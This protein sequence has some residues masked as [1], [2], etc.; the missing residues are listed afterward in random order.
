MLVRQDEFS[1]PPHCQSQT[2][3]AV[4]RLLCVCYSWERLG[5]KSTWNF[6]VKMHLLKSVPEF[7]GFLWGASSVCFLRAELAFSWL[8]LCVCCVSLGEKRMMDEWQ[9]IKACPWS[10]FK[11]QM[12]P[13]QQAFGRRLI[14]WKLSPSFNPLVIFTALSTAPARFPYFLSLWFC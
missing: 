8:L 3:K 10:G 1:S 14:E 7:M 9:R 4:C 12:M 11:F 6:L 2:E 13:H 5:K